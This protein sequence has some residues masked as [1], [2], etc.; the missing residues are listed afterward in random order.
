MLGYI[1]AG[2]AVILV[3][4]GIS[5]YNG[6]VTLRNRVRNAWAQIDVQLKNR[7]DLIPNLVETVK[8]YASH[9]KDTFD[10]V[11]KARSG[12]L[13]ANTPEES[14]E[15]NDM[16]SQALNRLMVVVEAYPELKANT[17]FLSLQN[18]LRDIED[19]IRYSRQF[20]NDTVLK[21]NTRIQTFPNNLVA[22]IF[23]FS[24]EVFFRADEGDR[25]AP[26]VQ[27]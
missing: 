26:R 22:G 15:A 27:F 25:E 3:L 6:F 17:N 14:M 12:V 16:L 4:Y 7:A 10:Q 11:V 8:G 9:E 23:G 2:V 1:I 13:N 18:D 20:Y 19:K 21:F 5:A 24:E